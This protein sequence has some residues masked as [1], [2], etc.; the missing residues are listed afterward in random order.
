MSECKQSL[1]AH[2]LMYC[3]SEPWRIAFCENKNKTAWA[4]IGVSPF[5]QRVYWQ[6]KS[7]EEGREATHQGRKASHKLDWAQICEVKRG[8]HLDVQALNETVH[9]NSRLRKKQFTITL[10]GRT[11]T[12]RCTIW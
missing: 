12:R 6:L 3:V 11:A 9:A 5:T 4:R 2:D 10:T 7:K 1:G 8:A